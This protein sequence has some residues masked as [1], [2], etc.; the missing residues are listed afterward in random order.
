MVKWNDPFPEIVSVGQSWKIWQHSKFGNNPPPFW[1]QSA[2][3]CTWQNNGPTPWI[4]SIVQKRIATPIATLTDIPNRFGSQ[5][6][7]STTATEFRNAKEKK[8]NNEWTLSCQIL[9]QTQT[10]K[11]T[12]LTKCRT[13]GR[14]HRHLVTI[15]NQNKCTC[16]NGDAPQGPQNYCP[17]NAQ[18][19]FYLGR[20]VSKVDFGEGK[21][22][23]GG[24]WSSG[25]KPA[26][27]KE[28]LWLG[29]DGKKKGVDPPPTRPAPDRVDTKLGWEKLVFLVI[30]KQ[31]KN[32]KLRPRLTFFWEKTTN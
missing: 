16:P 26:P 22:N 11:K 28:Y 17:I 31:E 10:Q 18:V 5:F 21:K 3:S 4:R 32:E 6:S 15:K 20:G 19:R 24:R 9:C 13:I 8:Q 12:H 23:R 30:K 29:F 7:V 2:W 27:W 14:R 1:K 25:S